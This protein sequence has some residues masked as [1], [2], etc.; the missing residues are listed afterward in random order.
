MGGTDD[1]NSFSLNPNEY[2][3]WVWESK[4]VRWMEGGVGG[5]YYEG[6]TA[7]GSKNFRGLALMADVKKNSFPW[8]K[9][10][11]RIQEG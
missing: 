5:Y 8:E 10:G 4:Q 7:R 9:D 1:P 11:R 6:R 3:N 2:E